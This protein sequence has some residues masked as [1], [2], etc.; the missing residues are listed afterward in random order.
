MKCKCRTM[1]EQ[2]FSCP[3]CGFTDKDLTSL[4]CLSDDTLSELDFLDIDAA[5]EIKVVTVKTEI[6]VVDEG[7]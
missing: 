3:N 5:L 4:C 7:T 2:S 1:V 6:S